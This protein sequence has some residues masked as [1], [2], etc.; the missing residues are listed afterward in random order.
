[1]SVFFEPVGIFIAIM[2]A[3]GLSFYFENKA[4]KEFSLLNTVND[5]EPV[6]VMRAGNIMLVPRRD[7][8]VGDIV[9]LNTGDEVPADG[10]L[11]EAMSL[12]V[13]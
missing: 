12:N 1:M 8:V 13:D 7:V 3:T 10:E 5:D 9:M 11:L 4:D 6:Q 2:L